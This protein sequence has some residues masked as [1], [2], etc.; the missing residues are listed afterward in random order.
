ME[1]RD[2][3]QIAHIEQQVEPSPWSETM[4][5]DSIRVGFL[6]W[7]LVHQQEIVGY[8]LISVVADECE[9]LNIAVAPSWQR[10][11]FGYELLS[12]MLEMAYVKGA[13][14]CHLE[15]RQSN[16]AAQD[17]YKRLSF[18]PAGFRKDYYIT[19]TGKEDAVTLKAVLKK[20]EGMK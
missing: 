13:R 7:V 16:V 12:Q 14:V 4:F 3:P 11:G 6:A 8:G 9:I 15:V 20:N 10:K 18:K 19:P 2:I 17:L 1:I 5:V